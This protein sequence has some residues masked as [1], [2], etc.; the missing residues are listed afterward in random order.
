MDSEENRAS[1]PD[2]EGNG[3]ADVHAETTDDGYIAFRGEWV[4]YFRHLKTCSVTTHTN[5]VVSKERRP[6]EWQ[7]PTVKTQS[8]KSSLTKPPAQSPPMPANVKSPLEPAKIKPP[9]KSGK[10]NSLPKPGKDISSPIKV[11]H[12]RAVVPCCPLPCTRTPRVKHRPAAKHA[13]VEKDRKQLSGKS[14][15]TRRRSSLLTSGATW[16]HLLGTNVQP[17]RHQ[18]SL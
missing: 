8:D 7:C 5:G 13:E 17:T 6:P 16:D 4:G 15:A 9:L 3:A 1:E 11:L 18:V 10:V 12:R 2:D 14:R